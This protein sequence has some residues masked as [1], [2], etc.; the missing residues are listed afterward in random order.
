ML[1]ADNACI[2]SGSSEGLETMMTANVTTCSALGLTVSEAET[3]TACL[4]TKYWGKVTFTINATGQVYKLTI[5]FVYL[6]GA[7]S[8]DRLLNIEITRLI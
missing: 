4:Q 7:I 6:G 8:A 1:Y 5:E 2:V 3:E